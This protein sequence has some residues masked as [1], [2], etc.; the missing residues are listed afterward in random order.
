MQRVV[1]EVVGGRELHDLA[2]VHDRDPVGDVPDDREVVRDEEVGEVEVALE[3]LHQVDDL[4]LDRDVK[5][6][7]GLV[8]N[9]EVR[10]ER[11]RAREADSLPLPARELMR[12]ARARVG[13]E[14]DRLQQLA[15]RLAEL[16]AAA[17]VDAQRLADHARDR[18]ARIQ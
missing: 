9:E 7:H 11:E 10:I 16:L 1:V 3:L 6:R 4:R 13:G 2:E 15:Y 12:I 17:A 18:V 5:G 8:A 14:A